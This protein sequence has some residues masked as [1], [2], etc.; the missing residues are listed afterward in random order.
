MPD[1]RYERRD[2]VFR[3][4]RLRQDADI[5]AVQ[6]G[7]R[8]AVALAR[9]GERTQARARCA[10]IVFEAQPAI[11]A[12]PGLLRATLHAL[13]LARGCKLLARLVL[14]VSGRRVQ[15]AVAERSAGPAVP[16]RRIETPEG[17]LHAVDS[18]WIAAVAPDDAAFQAWCAGL[19][20]QR[21]QRR[22]ADPAAVDVE[23]A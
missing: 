15:V 4:G 13:L 1:Q 2:A 18:N 8:T 7:L 14:A 19:L 6:A 23:L 17:M 20:G 3:P 10:A 11:A 21:A 9:A 12:C 16:P 22:D 5:A